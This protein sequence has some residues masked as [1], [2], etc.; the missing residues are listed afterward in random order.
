MPKEGPGP[1][2]KAIGQLLFRISSLGFHSDSGFRHSSA[3]GSEP[4]DQF[5]EWIVVVVHHTLLERN[6]RVVGYGDL[7]RTDLGAALGNVAVTDA[8][9]LLQ[10]LRA[11]FH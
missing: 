6:D 8:M 5:G 9:R 3:A 11:I 10:F 7:L 2:D 1:N 4:S